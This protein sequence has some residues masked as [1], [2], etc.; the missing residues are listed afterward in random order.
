MQ[1]YKKT[2]ILAALL[3]AGCQKSLFPGVPRYAREPSTVHGDGTR[4]KQAEE[5]SVPRKKLYLT[6]LSGPEA[7]LLADGEI[8]ARTA[9]DPD[10]ERHRARQGHLWTDIVQGKETV[11]FR[12]GEEWL[13][14]Q[15]EELLRGFHLDGG[16]LHTLGQR[17][18]GGLCYRI[19]GKEVFSAPAGLIVGSSTSPEWDSGA[20]GAD[21]SGLYFIYG[22]P[23]VHSGS[24]TW[25]YHVMRGADAIVTIP[26]DASGAVL[27]MRVF[28]GKVYRAERAG[29]SLR[30]ICGDSVLL[31]R[32]LRSAEKLGDVALVPI[33]E[34]MCLRGVSTYSG[35]SEAWM[36][37]GGRTDVQTAIPG[38]TPHLFKK[39]DVRAAWVEKDRLV[40]RFLLGRRLAHIPG[41]RYRLSNPLCLNVFD[42]SL[43]AI[44]SDTS[45]TEHLILADTTVT[46]LHLPGVPTS[47]RKE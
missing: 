28:R 26:D 22:I 6:L 46:P 33:G 38:W 39:G 12:D 42:N 18:G 17:P 31:S 21:S 23:F 41:G 37:C 27:D 25:E 4:V 2:L 44:F 47:I 35:Y 24:T 43:Y 14:Y 20:F 1:S 16:K 7:L 40:Q 15:G 11:V 3:L 19:D 30:L 45:G 8:I 32:R 29:G 10:P 5:D 13:R 9:A 34:E 36:I